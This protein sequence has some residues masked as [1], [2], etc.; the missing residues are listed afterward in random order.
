MQ[1][2]EKL[3]FFIVFS[4]LCPFPQAFKQVKGWFILELHETIRV[5]HAVACPIVFIL[6]F[7]RDEQGGV[8]KV[9]KNDY[10]LV[11]LAV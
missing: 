5:S 11:L 10:F 2:Y 4:R 1:S 3:S 8:L 6:F 7:D 9:M